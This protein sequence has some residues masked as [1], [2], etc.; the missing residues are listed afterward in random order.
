[1]HRSAYEQME[2]CIQ[3]YLPKSRRHRVVD[4]GSR[5]SGKQ[6]RTHRGLLAGHDIDYFGVDV[7]DGPNVDAVMR[8]P[9]R[10]PAK[11]R[12]ADVVLSGQAFEHI[13]FFW[14]SMME[15][16]RVLKPGGYAFIT[17]PSRGH[18]HDAQDCWRYYPDGFRAM[19]AHS[20]LELCEAYTDFPPTKGIWHDYGSIDTKAA[21][22]GDSVG[23]FRRPRRHPRPVARLR[24]RLATFAVRETAV[25]WANRVGGVDRVPLPRPLDG[26]EQCGRP[27]SRPITSTAG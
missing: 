7:L 1:M 6:T 18:A 25:W 12:S 21:Y 11:S 17:A 15:I 19:A 22:W 4:L 8:R 20:R 24:S 5:I 23:V 13:P 27:E 26:R 3:E 2:L 10:I 14:V 9:Y 16:A